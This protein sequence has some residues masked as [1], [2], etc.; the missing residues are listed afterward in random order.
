MK[1]VEPAIVEPAIVEPALLEP[2]IVERSARLSAF[3]HGFSVAP[4]DFALLRPARQ[5]AEAML[6]KQLGVPQAALKQVIQVHGTRFVTLDS[7][8]HARAHQEQEQ[9]DALIAR[10]GSGALVGIR[11]ADCVPILVASERTGDVAAVHAGWRGLV[12][13]II[14]GTLRALAV[15]GEQGTIAAIGPC[16]GRCCFEV[17]DEVA[18]AFQVAGHSE[19]VHVEPG[20]KPHV[21]LRKAARRALIAGGL[22]DSD[23]EDVGGCSRCEARYHSYR[24][25]G[26]TSGRMIA[27]IACR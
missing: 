8:H 18:V 14:E 25:D 1:G 9:A 10:A 5:E 4:Y 17:G 19:S 24:R 3:S 15:P 22:R 26:D 20:K 6:C 16:I 12:A 27:A 11:V 2:A 23:I 13:G 7:N 21:D